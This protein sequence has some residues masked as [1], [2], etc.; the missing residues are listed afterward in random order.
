MKV[1]LDNITLGLSGLTDNVY[2]GV[3]NKKKTMW[4]NKKDVTQSFIDC[5]IKRWEGHKE[6]IENGESQWE[7]TVEKLR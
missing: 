6:L 2:A 3:L 1:D 4:L 5:V 7:I